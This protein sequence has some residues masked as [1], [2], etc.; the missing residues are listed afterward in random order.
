MRW[1][2]RDSKLKTKQDKSVLA[3]IA[4]AKS[5]VVIRRSDERSQQA[6]LYKSLNFTPGLFIMAINR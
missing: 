6:I 4:V 2:K 5:S 3:I 1:A